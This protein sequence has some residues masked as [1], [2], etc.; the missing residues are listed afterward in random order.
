MGLSCGE[1]SGG[2]EKS[3]SRLDAYRIAFTQ[4]LRRKTVPEK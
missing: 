3:D 2:N 1:S 4:L